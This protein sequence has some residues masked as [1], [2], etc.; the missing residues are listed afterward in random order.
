MYGGGECCR[1]DSYCR[2]LPQT[3]PNPPRMTVRF[4]YD[5]LEAM[6]MRGARLCLSSGTIRLGMSFPAKS[7]ARR[8]KFQLANSSFTSNGHWTS[9][10]RAPPC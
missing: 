10:Y 5:G 2:K 9:S 1:P 6:P 7:G 8:S 4:D 3:R